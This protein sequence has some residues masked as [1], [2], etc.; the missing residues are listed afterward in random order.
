[1]QTQDMT[2][3]A[4]AGLEPSAEAIRDH[5]LMGLLQDGAPIPDDLI[6]RLS[7]CGIHFDG[8]HFGLISLQVVAVDAYAYIQG[9]GHTSYSEAQLAVNILELLREELRGRSG[10]FVFKAKSE[11]LCLICGAEPESVAGVLDKTAEELVA[12]E[13]RIA[14]IRLFAAVSNV[15]E[16]FPGLRISKQAVRKLQEYRILHLSTQPILRESIFSVPAVY[17]P[18]RSDID[19]EQEI[20]SL[21]KSGSFRQ[22]S[23]VFGSL[24]DQEY[25]AL[26]DPLILLKHKCSQYLSA[27]ISA[28]ESMVG[29][30]LTDQLAALAPEQSLLEAVTYPEIR[31]QMEHIFGHLNDW[32]LAGRKSTSAEWIMDVKNYIRGNY[33]D[34]DLNV[35]RVADEFGKNPSYLSRSFLRLTGTSIL[36]YIHFYR[37]QEAKILIGR[38][39][40]LAAAAAKVGYTNVLTMSRAFKKYEGTTPGKFKS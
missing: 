37:I 17:P 2:Q 23:E 38:G 18:Q 21:F 16:G 32:V 14:G 19:K 7:E 27:L 8:N 30:S 13:Q 35:N 40:T 15:R 3:W 36:D 9:L 28:C 4:D 11:V 33:N 26:A 34:P 29:Q 25:L 39:E 24:F 12:L 31:A 1:M 6:P 20:L 10:T 22:A 5:L